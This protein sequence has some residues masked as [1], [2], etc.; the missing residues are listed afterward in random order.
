MSATIDVLRTKPRKLT[1]TYLV[2]PEWYIV[3]ATLDLAK[4]CREKYASRFPYFKSILQFWYAYARAYWPTRKMPFNREYHIML[5]VI[6]FSFGLEMF[7]KGIYENTVGRLTW[8][9]NGSEQSPEDVLLAQFTEEYGQFMRIS[10]WYKFDFTVWRNTL[11]KIPVTG[12]RSLERRLFLI[13]EFWIKTKYARLI[14]M[15]TQANFA[16]DEETLEALVAFSKGA[17]EYCMKI[18]G[19]QNGLTL[20][21]MP[22]YQKF[23]TYALSLS[24]SNAN[25]AEIA[26]NNTICLSVRMPRGGHLPGGCRRLY[27]LGSLA[28]KGQERI[29]LELR[30]E[31]LA[32]F[33][34][35]LR[36]YRHILMEKIYDY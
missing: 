30:V 2:F 36:D 34:R 10:A 20:I 5:W 9:L 32:W 23:D 14:N 13:L 15:G 17:A 18:L 8:L 11:A 31:K 6:G 4:V 16:P 26:G 28:E 29:V 33:L 22:R 24:L 12:V 3:Y 7:L 19:Q 27:S 21:E 25:F 1:Q 35:S